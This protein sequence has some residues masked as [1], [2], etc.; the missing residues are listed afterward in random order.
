MVLGP[1]IVMGMKGEM[2]RKLTQVPLEELTK[3]NSWVRISAVLKEL[4]RK[5][6]P[7]CTHAV[8]LKEYF[9]L[10]LRHRETYYDLLRL[11]ERGHPQ[12]ESVRGCF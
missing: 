6:D 12:Q 9:K 4:G 10:S 2:R 3:D 5:E 8:L 1:R 7:R 11:S